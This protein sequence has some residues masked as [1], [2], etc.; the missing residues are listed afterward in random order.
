MS[1]RSYLPVR[2]YLSN[3]MV[4]KT[5]EHTTVHA[6][7]SLIRLTQGTLVWSMSRLQS[8]ECQPFDQLEPRLEARRFKLIDSCTYLK[9][10]IPKILTLFLD[11]S[12][13]VR[14]NSQGESANLYF[15]A[16]MWYF[17]WSKRVNHVSKISILDKLSSRFINKSSIDFWTK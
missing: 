14:I 1:K 9:K 10:Y 2:N 17:P 3:L 11:R 5:P 13:R 6:S 4:L 15:P 7:N 12:R 16:I 8:Y